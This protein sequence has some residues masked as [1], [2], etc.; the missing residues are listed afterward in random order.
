I[1]CKIEVKPIHYGLDN[2]A[3]CHMTITDKRYGTETIT[4]KGK[5][6]KFDS[7]ECL[8][9]FEKENNGN[10]FG[11][12]ITDYTNPGVLINAQNCYVLKSANLKSPMGRNL[13]GFESLDKAK[14]YISNQ[15]SDKILPFAEALNNF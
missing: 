14:T 9:D 5:V 7:I 15:Q 12:F 6:F 10:R 3:F 4:E 1:G 13:T 2:C 8:I 11:Y